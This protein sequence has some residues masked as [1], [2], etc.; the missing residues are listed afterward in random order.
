MADYVAQDIALH[1]KD[2]VISDTKRAFEER[3]RDV[4]MEKKAASF[5]PKTL[6]PKFVNEVASLAASRL[7][8]TH[9]SANT[10]VRLQQKLH[11]ESMLTDSDTAETYQTINVKQDE[12]EEKD[13]ADSACSTPEKAIDPD[14][15]PRKRAKKVSWNL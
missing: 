15:L 2:E 9:H 6:L 8:L 14:T 5:V 1:L 7:S 12:G 13:Q 10:A 11:A 4:I 3:I